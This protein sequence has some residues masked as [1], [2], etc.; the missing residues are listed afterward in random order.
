[1]KTRHQLNSALLIVA[2]LAGALVVVGSPAIAK[3]CNAASAQGRGGLNCGPA[4][5]VSNS[6]ATGQVTGTKPG[7]IGSPTIGTSNQN[8]GTKPP[9]TTKVPPST[10]TPLDPRP[11]PVRVPDVVPPPVTVN[12]IGPSV[13]PGQ[14]V[15]V[16]PPQIQQ[17][18]VPQIPIVL[19]P[20]PVP[21]VAPP[22]LPQQTPMLIPPMVPQQTPVAVPP[23]VP[24]QTPMAV[25]PI[26]QQQTPMLI[27]PMVPQ[28]T[29]VLVPVPVTMKIPP[30]VVG[31]VPPTPQAKPIPSQV[32]TSISAPAEPNGYVTPR[33]K[34]NSQT[35]GKVVAP[36]SS[37]TVSATPVLVVTPEAATASRNEKMITV[38]PGRQAANN[39][40]TFSVDSATPNRV[41]VVSGLERRK[42]AESNGTTTYQGTLP[43]FRMVAAEVADLPAWHPLDSGC[44][45]SVTHKR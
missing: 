42:T 33:P 10:D 24:Q 30:K 11:D 25:P 44:V 22:L 6:Q 13:P 41:C 18:V 28:Q 3:S 20:H 5:I 29:P 12:V 8:P 1:M 36:A 9:P 19:V 16:T 35:S 39:Y 43:T 15:P 2:S 14:I 7:Q 37:D 23:M 21:M 34:P 4:P 45:I 40:P 31:A 38:E 27:P 17:V 32:V 26:V